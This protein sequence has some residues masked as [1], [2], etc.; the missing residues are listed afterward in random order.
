MTLK[1][2]LIALLLGASL[3]LASPV[4]ANEAEF[5]QAVAYYSSQN[6]GQAFVL[7][8][9]LA[10]QGDAAAQY[11]LGQMYRNGQGVHQDYAQAAAWYRKAAEQGDA[12]AQ[13][14]LGVM[15]ANGKGVRQDDAQ[16]VAWYRKAAEQGNAMAQYNLGVMYYNGEGVRQ[17]K[18][19]AKEW[20]GNA[21][22]LGYQQGCDEY[23]RLNGLGY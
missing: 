16:A 20:F 10:E 19:T 22:D 8:N 3:S 12:A 17:N 11:N 13:Y 1:H 4:M 23:R 6:Y 5:A 14:N 15:Y 21:C 2:S 9:K 18:S 7:F